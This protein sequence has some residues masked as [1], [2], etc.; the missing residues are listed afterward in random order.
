MKKILITAFDPFG[1]ET[2][3]PSWEAVVRIQA[4]KDMDLYRLQVPTEFAA[5]LPAAKEAIR[6]YQPDCVLC[7]GMAGGRDAVTPEMIAINLDDARIPDNAGE[8][9]H[10]RPVIPGGP[11][12]Y[13][14]TL[15][16]RAMVKAMETAGINA[17]VSY[18][19]GTFVCNHLLYGLLHFAAEEYP[20]M[21]VGFIHVPALPE[22]SATSS[23]PSMPL[24][25]IV[26]AL[27]AAITVLR[28]S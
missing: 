2:I 3:N 23:G 28:K 24:E 20:H 1:G 8:E 18:T 10:D 17:K 19:A 6:K 27:E 4:P 9:P 21:K 11:A 13:F 22:Q 14:T 15:P 7:V 12:A 25:K 26:T 16:A 5:C